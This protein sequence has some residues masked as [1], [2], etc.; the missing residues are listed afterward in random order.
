MPTFFLTVKS[1]WYVHTLHICMYIHCKSAKNNPLF[2][3]FILN[4]DLRIYY[5]FLIYFINIFILNFILNM[6]FNKKCADLHV[7]KKLL[8]WSSILILPSLLFFTWHYLDNNVKVYCQ[9]IT[10]NK[11][12]KTSVIKSQKD[13]RWR[14]NSNLFWPKTR[15][16]ASY[17]KKKTR[18]WGPS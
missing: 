15:K 18:R 17:S 16:H 7:N 13:K 10:A 14:E 8:Y 11:S 4:I 3:H 1:L 12:R 9:W 2:I 6:Y 5:I